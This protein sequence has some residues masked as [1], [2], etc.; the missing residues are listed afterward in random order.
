MAE[1]ERIGGSSLNELLYLLA[2][3]GTK[4]VESRASHEFAPDI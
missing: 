1:N 2:S 4:D 3:V